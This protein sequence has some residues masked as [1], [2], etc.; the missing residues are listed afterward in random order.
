VGTFPVGQAA[1]RVWLTVSTKS[2]S[3][4]IT[5]TKKL[6]HGGMLEDRLDFH[7]CSTIWRPN[8][9]SCRDPLNRPTPSM[10]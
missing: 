9:G 8:G 6:I 5:N 10:V 7:F 4:I 1:L 2:T 3:S